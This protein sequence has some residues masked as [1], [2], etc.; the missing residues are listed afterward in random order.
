[1]LN[2]GPYLAEGVAFL[3]DA[4]ACMDRHFAKKFVRFGSLKAWSE[5]G[6]DEGWQA[7]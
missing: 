5:R 3:R 2:K 6:L 1:M 7:S 4:L